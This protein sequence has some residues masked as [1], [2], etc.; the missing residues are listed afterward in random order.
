MLVKI[1]GIT[2]EADGRAALAAG[3]GLLGFILAESPRKVTAA[4]A[5]RLVAALR[6]TPHG[7]RA[8]MVGVFK[9][10]PAAAVLRAAR[11]ARFDLVQLHGAEPPADALELARRGFRVLK[12]VKRLGRA[13]VREMGRFPAAWA[14]LLEKPVPKSWRGTARTADWRKARP[15]LAAHP[16]VG[17][18]GNLSPG[19][20]AR[21]VRGAGR[22]L[23]LVDAAS[24]LERAP[25]LKDRELVR[26]F[27]AAAR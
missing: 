1:C 10:A 15:A 16:R 4:E 24:T 18:A 26:R 20:V 5:A 7:R 27:A 3:A 21:A 23:W 17:I 19:N 14:F 22:G 12:V 25:G 2:N 8:L 9:D 11:R 6:R 13:A